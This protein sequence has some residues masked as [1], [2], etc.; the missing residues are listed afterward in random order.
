MIIREAR[1]EDAADLIRL[2]IRSVMALCR[3]DY[4]PDQLQDWISHST[5]EKYQSRLEQHPSYIAEQDGKM[6]GY[7]RWNPETNELCS[8]FV[9]PDYVRQGIATALMEVA[10]QDAKSQDVVELW[11]YASLTAVPFYQAIGWQYVERTMRGLLNCVK[12][13]KHLW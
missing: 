1:L 4:T 9:D 10:Y 13:T 6:I 11:L 5:L 7:V 3:D 8:I 12:M 2:H